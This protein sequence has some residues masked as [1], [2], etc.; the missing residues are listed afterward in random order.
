MEHCKRQYRDR[1]CYWE[2][3]SRSRMASSSSSPEVITMILDSMDAQ[4]HSWPRSRSML[5]KEF[6]GL[7]RPRLSNT[8]LI[9]HGHLISMALSPHWV[10][11]GSSRSTELLANA[12]SC[13]SQTKE[14]RNTFL[15]V[16]ADNCTKEVKN[17]CLIRALSLWTCRRMIRGAQMCFLTSG[18]SHEEVDGLFALIRAHLERSHE[19]HTPD[20]FRSS[21]QGW[22]DENAARRPH[23]PVRKVFLYLQFRDW[24]LRVHNV[25][26]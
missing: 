24:T 18:H 7:N 4:K 2:Y 15:H 17:N 14:L 10:T 12:L 25:S 9:V 23:E 11:T 19:L 6:N 16:Q 13:L 21:L 5:S 8:T 1:Q 3:R 26:E 20:Q 22:F